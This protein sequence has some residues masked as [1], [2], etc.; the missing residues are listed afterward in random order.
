M[1]LGTISID[2]E[3]SVWLTTTYLLEMFQPINGSRLAESVFAGSLIH[4]L[5]NSWLILF[6]DVAGYDDAA[7]NL[8][9]EVAAN[10]DD[11]GVRNLCVL[12]DKAIPKLVFTNPIFAKRLVLSFTGERRQ[13]V[14][15][16]LAYQAHRL[17]GG[18]VF[19][20]SPEEYLAQKTTAAY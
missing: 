10:I 1:Q 13:Q 11:R 7:L 17:G 15:E 5:Q 12:I 9:L 19:V 20:G 2:F 6:W 16:D 14:V 4:T 18:G 3:V 8:I